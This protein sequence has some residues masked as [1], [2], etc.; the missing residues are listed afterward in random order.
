MITS[1]W[2]QDWEPYDG[3]YHRLLTQNLW[4]RHRL[5]ISCITPFSGMSGTHDEHTRSNQLTRPTMHVLLLF[6]IS[7]WHWIVRITCGGRGFRSFRSFCG[8]SFVVPL[9][10]WEWTSTRC[11]AK[12]TSSIPPVNILDLA[13][14]TLCSIAVWWAFFHKT[15]SGRAVV[16]WV[17]RIHDDMLR[18]VGLEC[19]LSISKVSSGPSRRVK[20]SHKSR[21]C[22]KLFTRCR[23][24]T[25]GVV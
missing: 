2:S 5:S 8:A 19:D 4:R 18:R 12:A 23:D 24:E 17:V 16:V 14:L 11:P 15:R 1:I 9:F 7:F 3:P 20:L 21:G 6:R 10:D 25:N 13:M 22:W